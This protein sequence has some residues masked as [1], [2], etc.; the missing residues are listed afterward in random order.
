MVV[1]DKFCMALHALFM[2]SRTTLLNHVWP[3][4]GKS[5]EHTIVW[6]G[7]Y[8]IMYLHPY[9]PH[10]WYLHGIQVMALRPPNYIYLCPRLPDWYMQFMWFWVLPVSLSSVKDGGWVFYTRYN[11]VVGNLVHHSAFP[12]IC[13]VF[14][15]NHKSPHAATLVK[16][17]E[18]SWPWG[19]PMPVPRA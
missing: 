19:D 8:I 5:E 14:S 3:N 2:A 9:N 7:A 15:I 16:S 13:I 17:Y 1:G 12:N 4:L 18:S 6:G 10:K 11:K